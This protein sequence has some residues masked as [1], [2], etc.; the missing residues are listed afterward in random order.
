M[1]VLLLILVTLPFVFVFPLIVD[2]GLKAVPAVK[3]SFQ[4]VM[5]NA[6]GVLGMTLVYGVLNLVATCLCYFPV[7]FL[8][9]LVF[10]GF[11]LAYRQVFPTSPT[12]H[13]SS[14]MGTP[15]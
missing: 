8:L 7:F 14:E 5:T 2:R 12:S 9:P 6:F 1:I 3:A 10:G 11:F 13:A 15:T 4:G